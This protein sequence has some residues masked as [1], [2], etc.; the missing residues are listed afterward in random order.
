MVADGSRRKVEDLRDLDTVRLQGWILAR[1]EA[2][3]YALA[4][5]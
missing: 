4:A 5:V 3:L 1:T 2:R